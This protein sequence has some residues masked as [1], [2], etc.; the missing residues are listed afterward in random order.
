MSTELKLKINN[1]GE[2]FPKYINILLNHSTSQPDEID[3]AKKFV[4][5]ALEQIGYITSDFYT[6]SRM[7]KPY[8]IND[9][10][11]PAF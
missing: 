1:Y 7:Y 4:A 3:S 5:N 10:T 9:T 6:L 11:K 8:R 2:N